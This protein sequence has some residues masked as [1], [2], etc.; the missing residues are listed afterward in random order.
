MRR[1]VARAAGGGGVAGGGGF[2]ADHGALHALAG[3]VAEELGVEGD[4]VGFGAAE[5][6]FD[7]VGVEG[8]GLEGAAE[9][10]VD[11]EAGGEGEGG[12]RGHAGLGEEV[13]EGGVVFVDLAEGVLHLGEGLVEDGVE[14]AVLLVGE[15][16]GEGVGHVAEEAVDEADDFGEV[17]AADGGADLGGEGVEGFDLGGVLGVVAL[18][19]GGEVLVAEVE[20][21]E[22]DVFGLFGDAGADE[23]AADGDAAAAGGEDLLGFAV[24]VEAEELA[25]FG[26]GAEDGADGVV[27]ADL[28]E[29]DLHAGD[30][31]A[32]DFGAVADLGDVAFG[33]GEDVEEAG[34]RGRRRVR[35]R[36]WRRAGGRGRRRR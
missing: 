11:G 17:G 23:G 30:V 12:R 31:A 1:A 19:G 4:L 14:D 32:V 6:G 33:F 16:R 18:D 8:F 36:V 28:F 20:D 25:V 3:G 35:R 27:G 10:G 9:A 2:E 7:R 21:G 26:V 29:A 22:A 15:E 34:L 24:D 13:E 5:E